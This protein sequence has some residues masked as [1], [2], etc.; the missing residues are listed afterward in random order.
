MDLVRTSAPAPKPIRPASSPRDIGCDCQGELDLAEIDSEA[1]ILL[2][3][4]GALFSMSAACHRWL[5]ELGRNQHVEEAHFARVQ[6]QNRTVLMA[7]AQR[8]PMH[9][10]LGDAAIRRLGETYQ[11]AVAEAVRQ[12]RPICL[13]ALFD[14]DPHTVDQCVEAMLAP[15]RR[16]Y[17]EGLQPA[18]HIRVSS[19][20]LR[21]RVV[22]ALKVLL[23]ERP[24]VEFIDCLTDADRQLPGLIMLSADSADPMHRDLARRH[25]HRARS[26]APGATAAEPVGPR[27]SLGS[28]TSTH[29]YFYAQPCPLKSGLPDGA[30]IAAE[31]AAL[32]QA[33]RQ[34]QC[35]FVTLEILSEIPGH[36][37]SLIAALSAAITSARAVAPAL[38]VR[39]VTRNRK[40][41]E[42]MR[43]CV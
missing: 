5:A 41:R 28:D 13:T 38:K 39:I 6:D 18:I 21:E 42:G 36:E 25:A 16:C 37:G 14:Y 24:A 22:A 40:I 31:Y 33:A 10:H 1:V 15:V 34:H 19:S 23:A 4:E 8:A 17:Q 9:G 20:R 32:F 7:R 3:R 29:L 30:R 27:R 12:H 35:T 43:G 26:A 2:A 11:A